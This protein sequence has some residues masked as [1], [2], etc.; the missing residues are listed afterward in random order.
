MTSSRGQTRAASPAIE[1][2][3]GWVVDVEQRVM[4]RVDAWLGVE[5]DDRVLRIVEDKLR[6]ETERRSWRHGAE[7]F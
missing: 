6:E 1:P 3:P 7:A 5:L 4:D 2:E